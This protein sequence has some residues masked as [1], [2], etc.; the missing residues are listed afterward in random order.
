M[1]V[2]NIKP[3][4]VNIRI[5]SGDTINKTFSITKDGIAWDLTGY[6]IDMRIKTPDGRTLKI[7][8]NT[9]GSTEITVSGASYSILADSPTEV[10]FFN[11]DV[12][13]TIAG[14]KYTFQVGKIEIQKE[15]TP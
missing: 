9:G 13:V 1:L 14:A 6:D 12:Q 8:T 2:Y 3:A 11:Y 7:L 15:Y 5:T 10:G 4:V